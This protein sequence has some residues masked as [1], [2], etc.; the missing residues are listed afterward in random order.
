MSQPIK[1]LNLF[2]HTEAGKAM[3][4]S[5]KDAIN[6][7]IQSLQAYGSDR[8]TWVVGFSGGKDSTATITFIDWAIKA[9]QVKRPSNLIAIYADTLMELPSLES[10]AH[11]LLDYLERSGGELFA[12]VRYYKL[13]RLKQNDFS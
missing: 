5:L 11:E 10:N 7:S 3:R 13:I 8:S 9:G 1:Q 2:R 12:P 4:L 6:L